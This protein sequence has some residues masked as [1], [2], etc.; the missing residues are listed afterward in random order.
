MIHAG[1]LCFGCQVK[2]ASLPLTHPCNR[3]A[4]VLHADWEMQDGS[5]ALRINAASKIRICTE[6]WLQVRRR[7]TN[8]PDQPIVAGRVC[9][10]DQSV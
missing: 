5:A 9:V 10:A 8:P 1:D 4:D 7:V 6:I 2:G 3:E